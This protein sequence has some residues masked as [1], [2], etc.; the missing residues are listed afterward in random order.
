MTTPFDY[1]NDPER[2]RLAARVTQQ[3]LTVRSLYDQLAELLVGIDAWRILD[4]GCG[5]GALRAVL[6]ARLQS[7]LVGLDASRTMLGAHPPPVV[8]ANATAL[9][10]LAEVFDAVVAVN[11]LDHLPDPTVAVG[12]AHRVLRPPASTPRMPPGWWRRCSARSGSSTGTR[13][14]CG[15]PTGPRS[16]TTWWHGSCRPKPPPTPP[17]RSAHR[18]PSPS[19]VP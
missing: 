15:C 19:E 1:D 18:R 5:E 8:Q 4:I 17:S 14:W 2:F 10:F 16:A 13:R 3:H 6:P 7:W 11:V 12:E 9:P